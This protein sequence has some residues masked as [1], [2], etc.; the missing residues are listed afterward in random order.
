MANLDGR[1]TPML[2]LPHQAPT[3]AFGGVTRD[4]RWVSEGKVLYAADLPLSLVGDVVTF[5]RVMN[6]TGVSKGEWNPAGTA[7]H[8]AVAAEYQVNDSIDSAGSVD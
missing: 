7:S 2:D 4:V 6:A 5:P 8:K 3:T 1:T